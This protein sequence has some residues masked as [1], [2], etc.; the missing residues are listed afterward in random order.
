M[1]EIDLEPLPHPKLC[2]ERELCNVHPASYQVAV[3][4]HLH[5]QSSAADST[6]QTQR[7]LNLQS[8]VKPQDTMYV[9]R[10]KDTAEHYESMSDF[11]YWVA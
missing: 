1:L 6:C 8:S 3:D 11:L 9:R 5:L 7:R 10:Y 4:L 2:N